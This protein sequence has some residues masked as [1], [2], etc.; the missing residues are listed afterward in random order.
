MRFALPTGLALIVLAALALTYQG[1]TY[2]TQE[3]VVNFGPIKAT[4]E[5]QKTLP[6]PPP[7][8]ALVLAAGVALVI[9]GAKNRP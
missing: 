6:L 4:A 1:I 7:L 5:T 2:T 3:E 9:V 8:S